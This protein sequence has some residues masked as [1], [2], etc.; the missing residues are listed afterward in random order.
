MTRNRWRAGRRESRPLLPAPQV[1]PVA[2]AH[3][4]SSSSRTWRHLP[5]GG[6]GRRH[7]CLALPGHGRSAGGRAGTARWE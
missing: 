1:R 4:N 3:G 2:L 7:R 5:D 6:F